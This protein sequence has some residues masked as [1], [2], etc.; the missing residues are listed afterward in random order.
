[1]Q[2]QKAGALDGGPIDHSVLGTEELVA[3]TNGEH[4]VAGFDVL[5]ERGRQTRHIAGNHGLLVVLATAEEYEVVIHGV[6]LT[7]QANVINGHVVAA[8]IEQVAHDL[9][10]AAITVRIHEVFIQVRNLD[11]FSHCFHPSR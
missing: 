2:W 5:V 3:A 4:W 11:C 8:L 10:V 6:E 1:M 9:H 7:A